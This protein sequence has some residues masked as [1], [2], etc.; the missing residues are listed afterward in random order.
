MGKGD[1]MNLETKRLIIRRFEKSDGEDLF[2][3]LSDEDVVKFEPYHVFSKEQALHEAMKRAEK[4]EFLAVCLKDSKKLIGNIYFSQGDFDTW[5]LGYVFNKSYQKKGYATESIYVLLNYA[6]SELNVRRVVANCSPKN[7]S[8]WRLMERLK[9]RRE[10]L[11]L[12]NVY[13]KTNDIGEPIWLDTYQYAI[14][15]AE[16]DKIKDVNEFQDFL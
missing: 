11:M 7:T 12:Q 3:Y 4:K 6:F 16:W 8:S 9:M 13:F 15:K 2:E 10:G 14:L 5:E 1:S